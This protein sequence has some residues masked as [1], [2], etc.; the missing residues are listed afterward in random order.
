MTIPEFIFVFLLGFATCAVLIL[1]LWF[2][3]EC[4]RARAFKVMRL[5]NA[6]LRGKIES[7]RR[8]MVY[9]CKG[10]RE[11]RLGGSAALP[12]PATP[13]A[14]RLEVHMQ[15]SSQTF[16]KLITARVTRPFLG[17]GLDLIGG[18]HEQR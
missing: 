15:H 2:L 16:G 13:T 17:S 6:Q 9:I 1:T 11:I 14:L 4:E 8:V 5:E 7:A 10:L 12:T 3:R 18:S